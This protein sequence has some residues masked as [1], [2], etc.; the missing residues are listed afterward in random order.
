MTV[1]RLEMYRMLAVELQDP[2]IVRHVPTG[3]SPINNPIPTT[4]AEEVLGNRATWKQR[5][6]STGKMS[7]VFD[8]EGHDDLFIKRIQRKF[9]VEVK[10]KIEERTLDI[11][12]DIENN[13]VH[14]E[15]ARAMGFDVPAMEVR[16]VYDAHG[17]P[18]EAYYLMRKVKG[19][20]LDSKKAAE[21]FLYRE[22]LARHRA[23]ATLLGDFDRK[24]DNY[25]ITEEG[26]FVPIDAGMADVTNA[27]FTQVVNEAN[28]ARAAE[29]KPP[30]ALRSDHPATLAGN[31]GRDHW[32]AKCV[33]ATQGKEL[34]T[35][36]KK[37][38]RHMLLAEESMTASAAEQVVNDI[39]RYFGPNATPADAAE[40]VR[41]IEEAYTTMYL[42]ERVRKLAELRGANLADP[43][44]R[45]ALEAEARQ[46]LKLKIQPSVEKVVDHLRVRAPH[47][48]DVMKGFKERNGLSLL[49]L[50]PD[51]SGALNGVII[52]VSFQYL[53]QNAA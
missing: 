4:T 24:L 28:I 39:E 20:T 31:N 30:I 17:A 13:M 32:Y 52:P 42:P 5:K 8:V 12:A 41:L 23:L 46:S 35:Y 10:G 6:D 36:N 47:I 43:A 33:E 29:G 21:V 3:R 34:L 15:L 1:E 49:I 45:T 40:G 27:R 37:L 51:T 48:R 19:K 26:H 50:L 9:K 18:L 44:V 53:Y 25:L 2:E 14:T 38:Y 7:E 22:E 11:L 16:V